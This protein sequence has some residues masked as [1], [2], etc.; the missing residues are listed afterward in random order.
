MGAGADTLDPGSG[1]SHTIAS[2]KASTRARLADLG[3]E[4]GDLFKE[5]RQVDHHTIAN[6]TLCIA[7]EDARWYEVELVL[8][9]LVVVNGVSSIS[10]TLDME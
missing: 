10:A 4:G 7:V 9:T 5:A 2:N 6:D 1:R 8:H 3:G